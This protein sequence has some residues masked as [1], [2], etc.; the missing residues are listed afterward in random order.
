VPDIS[1]GALVAFG[2]DGTNL[3]P[4]DTNGARDVFVFTDF[5]FDGM[6]NDYELVNPCLN[7]LVADAASDPDFDGLASGNESGLGTSACDSDTDNDARSDSVDSCPLIAED[8]DGFQD[9]DG[10]PETDN[11]SDGITDTLDTG[12]TAFFPPGHSHTNPTIDCRNI[13]EDYDSFKDTDGCPEPD[14]DN[15]AKPDSNDTCP[16]ND[17]VMGADG[18]LGVGGDNNHNGLVDGSETWAPLGTSGNDDSV[19]TYEDYDGILDTDGC[20]DSP[21]D[22]VDGDSFGTTIG[23]CMLFAD[24]REAQLGTNSVRA[25]ADTPTPN[26]EAVD[27][28]PLDTNDDGFTDISDIVSI[29]GRFGE[30]QITS[31][32]RY[33]LNLDGFI[34]ISDIV[35]MS[36]RFGLACVAPGPMG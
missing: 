6:A 32:V 3:V 36:G 4:G 33:E 9:N 18:A 15:D 1:A 26:D 27:P 8:F 23:P 30:A 2:S 12:K 11:D 35:L 25:C 5:E 21:C 34:D 17:N 28:Y 13:A 20:H 16:G 14:N 7:V 31:N 22:D 24:E 19:R 10:C 29:T